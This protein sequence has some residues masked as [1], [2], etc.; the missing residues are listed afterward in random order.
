MPSGLVHA[1]AASTHQ[2]YVHHTDK[3]PTSFWFLSWF[4]PDPLNAAAPQELMEG[5]HPRLQQALYQRP[6]LKH[7]F[8]KELR[9]ALHSTQSQGGDTALK[10]FRSMVKANITHMNKMIE[11]QDDETF[12][13][14][15]KQAELQM[16]RRPSDRLFFTAD[17]GAPL[18]FLPPQ[19]HRRRR[20]SQEG[21][22]GSFL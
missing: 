17:V 19:L 6:K 7:A 11:Q 10:D 18:A 16:T 21:L 1:L 3:T 20:R 9:D 5:M 13:E 14:T 8:E 4:K 22:L 2:D 15:M 12:K